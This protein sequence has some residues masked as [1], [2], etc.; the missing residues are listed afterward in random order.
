MPLLSPSDRKTLEDR[1]KRE[2]KGEVSVAIF[3]T[4]SGLLA[5]PGRDCAYCPQVEELLDEVSSL[6]PKIQLQKYDYFDQQDEAQARGVQR[7]P[8]V[9]LESDGQSNIKYYGVPAG[10]EFVTLVEGIISLSKKVS[11]FTLMTRKLLRKIDTDV[12]IQVFVTPT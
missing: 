8:A 6:S 1:F 11:P 3:T 10:Y 7:I 12:H 9:L 4:K 2:L 5:I